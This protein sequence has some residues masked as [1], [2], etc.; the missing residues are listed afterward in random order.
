MLS[1]KE[2]SIYDLQFQTLYMSYVKNKY[3][4]KVS[5]IHS[6][7]FDLTQAG[8]IIYNLKNC[9]TIAIV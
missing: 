8:K 3:D 6:E 2:R 1:A 5:N 4:R 9:A 7:F